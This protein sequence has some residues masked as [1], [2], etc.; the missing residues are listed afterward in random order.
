MKS[1][2]KLVFV[3][4]FGLNRKCAIP[5]NTVGDGVYCGSV[6]LGFWKPFRLPFIALAPLRYL[7]G[8]YFTQTN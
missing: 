1:T 3:G 4:A 8:P 6:T 5:S 7:D 2:N